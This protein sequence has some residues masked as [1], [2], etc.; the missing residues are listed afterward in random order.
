MNNKTIYNVVILLNIKNRCEYIQKVTNTDYTQIN[1]II[2][3]SNKTIAPVLSR[4]RWV[5][6]GTP[7]FSTSQTERREMAEI[8]LKMV[9][10]LNQKDI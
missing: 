10:N 5:S 4:G 2:N 3:T 8:L 7:A 9:L 6:P 1:A